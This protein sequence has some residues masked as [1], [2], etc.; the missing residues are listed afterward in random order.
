[1]SSV[2]PVESSSARTLKSQSRLPGLIVAVASLYW[3][4]QVA[5]FWRYC[6]RNIN[7]DA[8]CYIG[9]ARHITDGNFRASLHGYWSP[10]I[11]WLIAAAS[12]AGHDR[13]LMARVVTLGCFALCLF[14]IY[15]LT[16]SLWGSRL[17]SAL[18]AVWFVAARSVAAFSVYFIGADLLLTALILTYFI[19]LLGC[20]RQ[21]DRS[22][23]WFALGVAHGFA[24]L[25]KAISMPLLAFA[26]VLAV[27]FTHGKSPRSAARA[28]IVSAVFPALVWIGWGTALRQKY[29]VFTTGYQLHWNLLD[30]AERDALGKT[31]MLAIRDTR[32]ISDSYLVSDQMP[33]GSSAWQAKV[34]KPSLI[35]EIAQKEAFNLP[36][37]CKELLVLL[38]PGGFLALGLC[39]WQLTRRRRSHVIYFHFCWIALLTTAM[40]A[41]AYS[42]LVFDGRY[43]LPVTALLMALSIRF[44][45]PSAAIRSSNNLVP[46]DIPDAGL[47]P[48]IVGLLIV[49]GLIFV[50]FYWA[51]PFRTIRQDFQR[52]TYDA[53]ETIKRGRART[54]VNIGRGP[55]PEHGVGWEAGYYAAYFSNARIAGELQELS[56]GVAPSSI[57]TDVA[58]LSPD[59]ILIWGI[60]ADSNYSRVVD[61]LREAYPKAKL[62]GIRDPIKGEVG[63]VLLL[64]S[65][66]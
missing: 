16:L 24:F 2:T 43:V 26:T 39:A 25:A 34:L 48:T 56:S 28:L 41:L 53:S 40:L 46:D 49:A 58:T 12:F 1:M 47:W 37:A 50:Q 57:V 7:I 3:L 55:Y 6:G 59:A 17:L 60:S 62:T 63:T 8:I 13:T 30:R 11:T 54:I 66:D 20:L 36:Q 44:A 14:L 32:Q 10:L 21:P 4:F 45:V 29:G 9:I 42:M 31:G 61:S 35:P 51:S 33:P 65:A 15:W 38:T 5:W 22:V 27:L 52:S 64:T 18:A 19:A 23:K